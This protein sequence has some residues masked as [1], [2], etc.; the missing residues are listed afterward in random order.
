MC[1]T[2]HSSSRNRKLVHLLFPNK[3]VCLKQSANYHV[4][5]WASF[6]ITER[7]KTTDIKGRGSLGIEPHKL[8][9]ICGELMDF[10]HDC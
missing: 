9:L 10:H 7:K 1:S 4:A 5:G 3:V 8:S 6:T 2:G